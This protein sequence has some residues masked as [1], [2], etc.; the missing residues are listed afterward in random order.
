VKVK[1]SIIDGQDLYKTP[2][3]FQQDLEKLINYYSQENGSNTPDFILAK[4]LNDCLNAF[5]EAIP[6]RE[7]WYGREE[8]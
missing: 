5:N 7:K 4:F 2:S 3:A 6:Q 1:E 8:K